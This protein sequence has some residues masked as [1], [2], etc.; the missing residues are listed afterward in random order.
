MFQVTIGKI[1]CVVTVLKSNLLW[2][3]VGKSGEG[4]E[5]EVVGEGRKEKQTQRKRTRTEKC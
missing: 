2:V 5:G 4:G 1:A 3:N